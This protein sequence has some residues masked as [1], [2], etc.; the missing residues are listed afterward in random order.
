MS[1]PGIR[2]GTAGRPGPNGA[3]DGEAMTG[4][5]A[6]AAAPCML[7]EASVDRAEARHGYTAFDTGFES[8]GSRSMVWG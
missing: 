1:A 6:G 7:A 2:G 4:E 5:A 8:D 3:V